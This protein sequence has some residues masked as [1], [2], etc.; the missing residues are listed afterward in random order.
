M[1]EYIT[2]KAHYKS[3]RVEQHR[4]K[5]TKDITKNAKLK[6]LTDSLRAF[7]TVNKVEIIQPTETK[8]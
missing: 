2:V 7:P 1:D 8:L 5:K 4:V 6:K 3:G